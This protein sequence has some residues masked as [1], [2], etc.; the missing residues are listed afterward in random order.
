MLFTQSEIFAFSDGEKSTEQRIVGALYTIKQPLTPIVVAALR[1]AASPI[2]IANKHRHKRQ[3][4]ASG[5][6][7]TIA[8]LSLLLSKM[9]TN[10]DLMNGNFN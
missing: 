9:T 10:A 8:A 3:L 4:A 6:A 2:P 5:R 1:C 7:V